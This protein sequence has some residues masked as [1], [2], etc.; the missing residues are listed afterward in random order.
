MLRPAAGTGRIPGPVPTARR[1]NEV[2]PR[3]SKLQDTLGPYAEA[4][5]KLAAQEQ[6]LLVDLYARSTTEVERLGPQAS[7]ERGPVKDGKPD[8]THLSPHGSDATAKL[9]VD[10]LRKA[11]PE[12]GSCLK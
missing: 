11:A 2:L 9:V 10:E 5:R 7:D 12:L 8:H 1:P 6:V 3:G 4:V